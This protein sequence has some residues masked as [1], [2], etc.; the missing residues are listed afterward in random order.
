MARRTEL[1]KQEKRFREQLSEMPVEY[2]FCHN[3]GHQVIPMTV[4]PDG[5]TFVNGLVCTSCAMEI[6]RWRDSYTGR[7]SSR[8]WHPRGD[9]YFKGTGPI[10]TERKLEIE[11]AW[12]DA[13]KGNQ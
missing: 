11:A 13:W 5:D 3:F 9:Y 12:R 2:L 7:A 10:T 4:N 8:Y 6:D 1:E